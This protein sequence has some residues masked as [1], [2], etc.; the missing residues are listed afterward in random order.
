[1][2]EFYSYDGRAVKNVSFGDFDAW[3]DAQIEGQ[4][5]PIKR[6][7]ATMYVP[8]VRRAQK[9]RAGA[10]RAVPF[11]IMQGE[12]DITDKERFADIAGLIEKAEMSMTKF[13]GAYWHL[14]R[15]LVSF[16]WPQW[17]VYPSIE[18][19]YN[20]DH[21]FVG[22]ER[23]VNNRKKIYKPNEL[24]A[25][26]E[27]DED[28]EFGPGQ[29]ALDAALYAASALHNADL[30]VDSYFTRDGTR[31]TIFGVDRLTQDD[32]VEAL[33]AWWR[34][35]TQG[36]RNAFVS[37]FYR[38][39]LTPTIVGDPLKEIWSAD[40]TADKQ[41]DI[42]AAFGMPVSVLMSNA[43]DRATAESDAMQ[44]YTN[45]V[46]PRCEWYADQI[47]RQWLSRENPPLEMVYHPEQTEVWQRAQLEQVQAVTTAYA[48]GILDI[49]EAR[50]IIG[51]DEVAVVDSKDETEPQ[52]SETEPEPAQKSLLQGDLEKWER[53]AT[54]RWREGSREKALTFTSDVIPATMQAAIRGALEG[55]ESVDDIAHAFRWAGY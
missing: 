37:V 36:V 22:Y 17:W 55:A 47:N 42:A 50:A 38:G 34:R 6:D 15:N 19:V 35:L 23:T 28:V 14:D 4:A 32:Q 53:K 26:F 2:R 7:D 24:V 1:M 5:Q 52:T 9:L 48:A 40:L 49:N 3:M 10:V 54:Q 43:A 18:I 27:P 13:G 46:F 33:K 30:M 20:T 31:I 25:F 29:A 51:Y 45:F 16:V 41:R 39:T 12:T 11:S 21:I 44:W 8:W